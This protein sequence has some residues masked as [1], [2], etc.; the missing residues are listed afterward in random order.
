MSTVG[1]NWRVFNAYIR[2]NLSSA[3]E[4]RASFITQVI[5]MIVNDAMWVAFWWLYFARFPVVKGWSYH[6]VVALWAV[7]ATGYG[8][9]AILFGNASRLAGIIVRGELDHFLTLPKNVLLHMLVSRSSLSAW[10]DVVFG[11]AIIF[12]AG[13]ISSPAA[14]ALFAFGAIVTAVLMTSFAVL[15]NSLAFFLGNAEG[16]AGQ[17][18]NALITLAGY[19]TPIFRGAARFILFTLI[20]AGMISSIPV[21]LLRA[22]EPVFALE[23]AAFAAGLALLAYG[24][25]TLG[26]KRYE[27]GN[28]MTIQM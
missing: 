12:L 15:A 26:L 10:G 14:L 16:L 22:F 13:G 9:G 4:Y 11:I 19:P 25:F 8:M 5:T 2:M 27:S 24:V 7:L 28:L 1:K 17:M 6:D 18:Y 20:P 23:A 21:R 3:M